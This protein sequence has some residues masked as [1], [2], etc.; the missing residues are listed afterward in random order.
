MTIT[1]PT[2]S[3]SSIGPWLTLTIAALVILLV[4]A[5]SPKGRKGIF[6]AIALAALAVAAWQSHCLWGKTG[7]DFS[8]MVY[9]DNF[10]FYF[11]NIIILGTALTIL[12][13]P[14]YLE[15]FSFRFNRFLLKCFFQFT[16]FLKTDYSGNQEAYFFH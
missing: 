7:V 1:V 9:L 4:D 3:L 8:R 16:C 14:H 10:A 5:F 15:E 12:M 11:Y 6:P 2:F 13:S